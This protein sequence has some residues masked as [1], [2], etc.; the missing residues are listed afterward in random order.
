[1]TDPQTAAARPHQPTDTPPRKG[2]GPWMSMAMVVGTLIGSGIFLMPAV[3]A[4]YGPNIPF[5]WAISIGGTFCIAYCLAQL[6]KCIPGG[7]VVYITRA[8]GDLPAFIAVWSY[9]LTIW[10]G[11]AAVALAMAGALAYVLPSTATTGGIF[12]LSAGSL[13]VLMIINLLGIRTAGRVQVVATLIKLIPLVLVLLFVAARLG[14]GRPLEPL[15]PVPIGAMSILGAASLTLFSLTG[16][17][18]GAITA[19]V[20][21][22][23]ERNVPRAQ[24]YGVAFTGFMYLMATL[25]VLWILPSDVAAHSKAPFADAIAPI[26]GGEAGTFVAIIVAISAFGANNALLLGGAEILH[27]IARQGDVPPIFARTRANGVPAPAVIGLTVASIAL[28]A[29]SSAP[30]FVEIYAFVSLV[31]AI[32]ALVLYALCSAAALKLGRTGG[33]L[34]TI[35]AVIGIVYSIAMFFGA[36]W[37]ATSWGLALA[38]AGL[39]IRWA[40]RRLW[41]DRT[42]S[43]VSGAA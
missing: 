24:V 28:L 20:T 34:G 14:G 31:S 36:G 12:T 32:G 1:M 13:I 5:A 39:P 16:F 41:P 2:F 21:E 35:L 10:S 27:S 40:S 18:I 19:P 17:E 6:A 8:F 29:F 22:N 25:A 30:S 15:A 11:L 23:A 33:G 3:L 43:A 9:V 37:K 4:P 26:L 7:P 42:T 38:L